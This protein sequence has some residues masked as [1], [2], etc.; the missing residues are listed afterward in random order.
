MMPCFHGDLY[1]RLD[2]SIVDHV[3]LGKMLGLGGGREEAVLY[4]TGVSVFIT[5]AKRRLLVC[6]IIITR[7]VSPNGEALP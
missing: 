5:L 7:Q 6:I 4:S 3:I 1:K 2:V